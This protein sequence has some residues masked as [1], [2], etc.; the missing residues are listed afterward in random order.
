[1]SFM[2]KYGVGLDWIQLRPTF[3]LHYTTYEGSRRPQKIVRSG[4]PTEQN[5]ARFKRYFQIL[6]MFSEVKKNVTK[7]GKKFW[8]RLNFLTLT[9]PA[10]LESSDNTAKAFALLRKKIVYHGLKYYLWRKEVQPGTGNLHWHIVSNHFIHYTD[11]QNL[12]NDALKKHCHGAMNNFFQ[13]HGHK[14]PPTTEV[15]AIRTPGKCMAYA[16]KYLSKRGGKTEGNTFGI[17]RAL[18]SIRY[19]VYLAEDVAEII[20]EGTE[21]PQRI[22]DFCDIIRYDWL[23][24]HPEARKVLTDW[25]AKTKAAL[26]AVY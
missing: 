17:S 8:W 21:K 24:L 2:T 23:G 3:F 10:R 20:R 6:L 26:N 11:L 25:K 16:S 13:K 22:N 4:N 14:N 19:P 15:K 7:D 18:L 1:M 9:I 12:W 5:I